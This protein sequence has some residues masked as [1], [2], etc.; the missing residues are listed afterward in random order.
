MYQQITLVGNLGRDV[1]LRYLPNGTPVADFTVAVNRKYTSGDGTPKDETT[2]H[3]VTVFGKQA[4]AC[5]EYLSKGRQVLVVGRVTASAWTG[6]DGNPRAT[7]EV[8]A[9]TVQFLGGAGGQGGGDFTSGSWATGTN[10]PQGDFPGDAA[11]DDEA[12]IPF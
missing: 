7:L 12:P 8:T 10:V 4:E 11:L 9:Q 6:Q 3:K 1:E 5:N 2:W